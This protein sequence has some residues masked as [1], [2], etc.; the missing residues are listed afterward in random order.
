M[1]PLRIGSEKERVCLNN[2]TSGGIFFNKYSFRVN[3]YNF[4]GNWS[5][6]YNYWTAGTQAGCPGQ[7]SWCGLE[8]GTGLDDNLLWEK[9]QPDNKGGK[10]DCV[11]LRIYSNSTGVR[12]TD[13]NCT[14]KM[15]F[16][17]E[18]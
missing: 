3:N 5:Y 2:L 7:W 8:G 4:L 12:L 18:V 15:I 13:R 6:N 17:C 14:S 16:A 10:E 1:K 9:G 11:H